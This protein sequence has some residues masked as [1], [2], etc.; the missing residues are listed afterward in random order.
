M[1]PNQIK[2]L[3]MGTQ[4]RT[5]RIKNVAPDG[6]ACA[7]LTTSEKLEI[8]KAIIGH[9]GREKQ[10][11]VVMLS[12]SKTPLSKCFSST[13]KTQSR[14]FRIP[15]IWRAFLRDRL[16]WTADLTVKITEL[17]FHISP[18]E[19]GRGLDTRNTCNGLHGELY[20]W[21]A[22]MRLCILSD[23]F[24]THLLFP[25]D[26]FQ[27]AW[28]GIIGYKWYSGQQRKTSG[29]CQAQLSVPGKWRIH[30]SVG[31]DISLWLLWMTLSQS[32]CTLSLLSKHSH[33]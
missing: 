17:R 7:L 10:E 19:C 29:Q 1:G 32:T 21:Q 9:S 24:L 20:D 26:V 18:A 33:E 28:F 30:D 31:T 8:A 3:L 2:S 15:P 4:S 11:I 25:R 13:A 22:C 14:H 16:V 5:T 12:F 23:L 6:A 27:C